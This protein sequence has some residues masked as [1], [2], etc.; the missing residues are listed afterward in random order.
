VR[1]A[2]VQLFPSLM[3]P[4]WIRALGG[5]QLGVGTAEARHLNLR[6][7]C[8]QERLEITTRQTLQRRYDDLPASRTETPRAALALS[9]TWRPCRGAGNKG[10]AG[11]TA[12]RLNWILWICIR[13]RLVGGLRQITF[14]RLRPDT[15]LSEGLTAEVGW[16]CRHAFQ[17]QR[18]MR[19]CGK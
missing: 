5:R 9:P 11:K 6:A 8:E 16:C 18:G 19:W 12:K 1:S 4:T 14:S 3:G 13:G 7:F 17:P 2:T 10:A 15:Q